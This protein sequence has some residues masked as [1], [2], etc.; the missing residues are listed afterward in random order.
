MFKKEENEEKSPKHVTVN[1]MLNE[2]ENVHVAPV[3]LMSI[4]LL[5]PACHVCNSSHS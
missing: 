4:L 3:D 1:A 5:F 2:Q